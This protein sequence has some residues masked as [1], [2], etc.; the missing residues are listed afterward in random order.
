[1]NR[2]AWTDFA[3]E[4]PSLDEFTELA[5][6]ALAEIP[7][8]FKRHIE[9]VA[10]RIDDW[11][12]KGTLRQ[13][14]IRHPLGLLG[15]YRGLPIGFK[16]AGAVVQHVDM[17]FLYRQPI[18]AHWRARGGK[19]GDMIRHVLVHEIGHHFGLSDSDM[20]RIETEAD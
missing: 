12:D 8:E 20:E 2:A 15:L 5:E 18:L 7:E 17:I 4:G 11:P 1:M 14:R 6:A 16:Q 10:L 3:D 19:L 9:G 13:M